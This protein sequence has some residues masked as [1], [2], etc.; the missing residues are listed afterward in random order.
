M[1]SDDE[2]FIAELISEHGEHDGEHGTVTFDKW[3]LREAARALLALSGQPAQPA[4]HSNDN[5]A[6]I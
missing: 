4:S 3:K 2:D 6:V 1:S 5:C